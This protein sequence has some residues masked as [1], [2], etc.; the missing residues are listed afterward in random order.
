MPEDNQGEI[1]PPSSTE[2]KKNGCLNG[3]QEFN[4][5]VKTGKAR[6]RCL[7]TAALTPTP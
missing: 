6:R 7:R 1:K 3:Y 5:A 2:K 4:E